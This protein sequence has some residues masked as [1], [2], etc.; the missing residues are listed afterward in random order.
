MRR[1]FLLTLG[2][3]LSGLV[4]GGAMVRAAGPP[5]AQAFAP[6]A[7]VPG[8]DLLWESSLAAAKA[9]AQRENKPIFLFH[10][11]GRLDQEFC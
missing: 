3:G 11:F 7:K 5:R 4:A 10:L 9:R 8:C 1:V 2:L 6:A